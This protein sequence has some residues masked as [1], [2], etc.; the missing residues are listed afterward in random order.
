ML[1]FEV[2]LIYTRCADP[3]SP[4]APV[5]GGHLQIAEASDLGPDPRKRRD[6]DIHDGW[7]RSRSMLAVRQQPLIVIC[8]NSRWPGR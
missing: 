7:K 3:Q 6:L 8:S 5:P 4:K 2:D 1:S